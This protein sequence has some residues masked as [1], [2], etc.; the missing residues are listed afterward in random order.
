MSDSE[1]KTHQASDVKLSKER[2]KGRIA[3]SADLYASAAAF[4]GFIIFIFLINFMIQHIKNIF[5]AAVYSTGFGWEHALNFSTTVLMHEFSTIIL[6][7][8]GAIAFAVI[9]S[10]I[11]YNKGVPISFEPIVPK[12]EKLNPVQGFKNIFG[13]RSV[14]GA[15]Q[16]IVRLILWVGGCTF[17]IWGVIGSLFNI[18]LCGDACFA[19]AGT[20]LATQLIVYACIIF[21]I[22]A[23][24]DMPI[25]K[26]LFMKDQ[27]MGKSEMKQENK[28]MF[29]SPEIRQARREFQ[30]EVN[31]GAGTPQKTQQA[32]IIIYGK[33]YAAAI[34]YN[35]KGQYG[36]SVMKTAKGSSVKA[37][38][39]T[40]KAGSVPTI[41]ND[42]LAESLGS[43]GRGGAIESKHFTSLAMAM[44][45]SGL[46]L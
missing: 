7:F 28:D 13:F 6:P 3:K 25:Q 14:V 23:L 15:A 29:G 40:A 38:L 2:D 35:P 20:Q 17:I 10:N 45:Q 5:D 42:E 21:L 30:R 44:V 33:G 11:I 27:K 4:T 24:M 41:R 43:K 18:P 1:E 22:I 19:A 9:L 39:D 26:A 31:S 36:P 34:H 46:S 32:T 37:M 12:F 16:S 8:F